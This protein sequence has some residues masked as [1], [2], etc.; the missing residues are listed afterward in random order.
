MGI[1]VEFNPELCL[2]HYKTEGRMAKECLPEKL[3]V[4]ERHQFLKRNHRYYWLGGEIPLRETSGD[5]KVSRPLASIRI[6]KFT[7]YA[8]GQTGGVYEIME[9]Y[10]PENPQIHFEGLEKISEKR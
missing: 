10:N 4:G 8:T 6:K 7:L 9:V 2:R 1:Q 5:G 3:K